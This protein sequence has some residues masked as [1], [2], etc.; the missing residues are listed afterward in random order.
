[1]PKID[2]GQTFM[3]L[4]GFRG[5][6]DRSCDQ[7]ADQGAEEGFPPFA[8]IV[9]KLEEPKIDGE[10]FLRDATVRSQP[11]AQEGPEAL[12]GVDVDLTEAIAVFIA[13]ILAPPMAHRLVLVTPERQPGAAAGRG[14]R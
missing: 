10:L 7:G 11:G 14:S 3:A 5:D 4:T 8:C 9:S 2:E 6:A 13:R 12:H 1:M